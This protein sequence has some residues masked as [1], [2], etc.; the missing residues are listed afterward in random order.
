MAIALISGYRLIKEAM[1]VSPLDAAKRTNFAEAG[2]ARV[3]AGIIEWLALLLGGAK[4]VAWVADWSLARADSEPWVADV[5]RALDFVALPLF[6]YGLVSVIVSSEKLMAAIMKPAAWLIAGPLKEISLRH[7]ATRR[8]RAASFLLI[9]A[10]MTSLALY[11]TV[12]IAVFDNKTERAA[13]VQLGGHMQITLN[14]LDLTPP[15]ARAKGELSQ[16]LTALQAGSIRWC[17][18]WSSCRK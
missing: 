18:S 15:E 16:R 17:R 3:R 5:D 13:R 14:A 12:M 7:M 1:R 10:L 8:H 11:P 9:V 2:K 6:I 4:V